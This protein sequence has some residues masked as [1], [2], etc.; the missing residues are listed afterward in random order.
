DY[1]A[2]L[3][4]INKALDIESKTTSKLYIMILKVIKLFIFLELKNFELLEFSLRSTTRTQGKSFPKTLSLML[5]FI[6]KYPSANSDKQMMHQLL[7]T[8]IQKLKEIIKDPAEKQ[9]IEAFDFLSLIE[10]K[11]T[12]QPFA[13]IIQGK[14]QNNITEKDL[15]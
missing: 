14:V 3:S 1:K 9:I 8:T 11:F 10:S 13:R 15:V 6:R 2:A 12:G 4:W 7:Q 5:D